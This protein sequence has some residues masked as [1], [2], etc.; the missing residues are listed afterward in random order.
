MHYPKSLCSLI[1]YTSV[2]GSQRCSYNF[3]TWGKPSTSKQWSKSTSVTPLPKRVRSIPYI[4]PRRA[5]V[6]SSRSSSASRTHSQNLCLLVPKTSLTFQNTAKLQ[7]QMRVHNAHSRHGPGTCHR[8]TRVTVTSVPGLVL[9]TLLNKPGMKA[10]NPLPKTY[11]LIISLQLSDSSRIHH[12][13][14]ST[15]LKSSHVS[16][17]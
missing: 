8:A 13:F 17:T 15:P 10:A 5:E 3:S 9:R 6:K 4:H 7:L 12:H 11:I 2:C 1:H 16:I 14:S